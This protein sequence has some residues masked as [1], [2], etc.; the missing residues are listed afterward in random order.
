[1]WINYRIRCSHANKTIEVKWPSHSTKFKGPAKYRKI[2][3]PAGVYTW[4]FTRRLNSKQ[5]KFIDSACQSVSRLY[6]SPFTNNEVSFCAVGEQK[7]KSITFFN[8][9]VR[10]MQMSQQKYRSSRCLL[11]CLLRSTSDDLSAPQTAQLTLVS[12]AVPFACALKCLWNAFSM[13][14]AYEHNE[15]R[16]SSLSYLRIEGYN[17]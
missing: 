13:V 11:M 12:G 5:S 7:K 4:H 14:H 1:M 10:K 3:D 9:T 15:H 17:K 16:Y 8:C 2:Y 6:A